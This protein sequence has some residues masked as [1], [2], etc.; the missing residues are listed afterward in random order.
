MR[1]GEAKSSQDDPERG[2]TDS[3]KLSIK[4]IAVHLQ[5]TGLTFSQI[6]HSMK[7]RAIET[8]EIMGQCISP[9]AELALLQNITP[10][11]DPTLLIPEINSWNKDTLVTSHLPFIP[12]LLTLL[13]GQDVYLSAITFET[14]TIVCLEKNDNAGWDIK[15]ATAPSEI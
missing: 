3:G 4:R 8:A 11:D 13:T 5:R 15:W 14:G 10:N 7:K 9:D 2:L 6:F 12:N 1:H